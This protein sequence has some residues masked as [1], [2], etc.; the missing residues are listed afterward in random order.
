MNDNQIKEL[1]KRIVQEVLARLTGFSAYKTLAVF[2]EVTAYSNE[3]QEYLSGKSA[4]AALFGEAEEPKDIPSSRIQTSDDRSKVI[5]SLK[6]IEE[7]VLCAPSLKLLCEIADG[8]DSNFEAKVFEKAILSGKNTTVL[9]D[10]LPPKFKKG[11]LFE[12][13]INAIDALGDMGVKI[14]YLGTKPEIGYS[15]ITEYEVNE[16]AKRG[17]ERLQCAPGAVVTPLARDAAKDK[18]IA[19][20][21]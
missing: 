7:V 17:I 14:V 20:D 13:A 21:I 5:K 12:K 1:I 3:A 16:A 9:L 2:T 4:A 6:T 10:F 15:L 18:G 8:D 11:T 19:I